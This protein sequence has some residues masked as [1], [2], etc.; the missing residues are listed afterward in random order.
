MYKT[1]KFI[2]AFVLAALFLLVSALGI[3][4]MF[5]NPVYEK[6]F[7]TVDPDL[8][9]I[10]LVT[11]IVLGILGRILSRIDAIEKRMDQANVPKLKTN[12]DLGNWPPSV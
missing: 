9:W 4:A 11:A 10:T 2:F 8:F 12:K 6:Y 1:F 7:P 5:N 3:H